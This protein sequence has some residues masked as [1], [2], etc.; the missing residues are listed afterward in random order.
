M[1]PDSHVASAHGLASA[2]RLI[3]GRKQ[4]GIRGGRTFARRISPSSK[5]VGGDRVEI[6]LPASRQEAYSWASKAAPFRSTM[7]APLRTGSDLH[8][9]WPARGIKRG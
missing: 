1:G 8:I 5:A 7:S 9:R 4:G 6:P 3:A 2:H